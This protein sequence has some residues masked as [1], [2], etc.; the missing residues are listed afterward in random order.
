MSMR[1]FRENM[2]VLQVTSTRRAS[3]AAPLTGCFV[4]LDDYTGPQRGLPADNKLRVR[5]VRRT[6]AVKPYVPK[7]GQRSIWCMHTYFPTDANVTHVGRFTADP[8]APH[9]RNR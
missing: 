1:T 2:T 3:A 8:R 7:R 6:Y 4:R 5:L 9:T